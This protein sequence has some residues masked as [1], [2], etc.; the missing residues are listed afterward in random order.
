MQKVVFHFM[1]E[2][3]EKHKYSASSPCNGSP[4]TIRENKAETKEEYIWVSFGSYYL[5]RKFPNSYNL[6][7][8]WS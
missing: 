7:N 4:S 8:L 2:R 6:P 1:K 3:K 5:L